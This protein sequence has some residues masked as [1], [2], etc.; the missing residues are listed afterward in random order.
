MYGVMTAGTGAG[1]IE[2]VLTGF[3]LAVFMAG[4]FKFAFPLLVR[5]M[6]FVVGVQKKR[7]LVAR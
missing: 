1:A 4:F 3:L 6:P 5:V 7:A 2:G